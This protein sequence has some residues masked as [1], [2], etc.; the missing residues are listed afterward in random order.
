MRR[1]TLA[2]CLVACMAL[3]GCLGPS[4]A[5]WGTGSSSVQVDFSMENSTVT[6]GLSGQSTTLAGLYPAGC[7]PDSDSPQAKQ[8][9]PV[10]FSG[11]LA[12]SQFYDQHDT[13]MGAKGLDYG[14]LL[15]TSDAADE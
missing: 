6:S 2:L 3:A 12:A 9:D 13:L 8:G 14:C 1:S 7:T 11:Y 10:R 4:S 15:Y 5:D